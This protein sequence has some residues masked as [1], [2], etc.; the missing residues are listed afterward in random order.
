MRYLLTFAALSVAA[1]LASTPARAAPDPTP[2]PQI[3]DSPPI[4]TKVPPAPKVSAVSAEQEFLDLVA[5]IPGVRIID[6]AMVRAAACNICQ[7]LHAGHSRAEANT[8]VL[9]DNRTLTPEEAD[10]LV[11]ASVD[12]ICPGWGSGIA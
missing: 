3:A 11:S 10:D 5:K 9:Q 1:V 8:A 12:V 6:P 2:V 7:F 4:A